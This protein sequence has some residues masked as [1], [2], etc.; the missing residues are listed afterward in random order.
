MGTGNSPAGRQSLSLR[1]PGGRCYI[2]LLARFF[3]VA[4]AF[5]VLLRGG[6]SPL[7]AVDRLGEQSSKA[8]D[9]TVLEALASFVGEGERLVAILCTP[10]IRVPR[11][12]EAAAQT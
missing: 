7:E 8:Y 1:G 12:V 3:N 5:E 2:P 4:E 6:S 9:P 11:P 10:P